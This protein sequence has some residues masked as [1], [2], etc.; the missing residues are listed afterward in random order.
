MEKMKK[1]MIG[2]EM[3]APVDQERERFKKL[4][5]KEGGAAA[6]AAE[7]PSEEE[8]E[9]FFAILRRIKVAVKYFDEKGRRGKEWREAVEQLDVTVD[10]GD[11]PAPDSEIAVLR[12]KDEKVI[13]NKA[14]DLN[15]VAPEAAQ[16]GGA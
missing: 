1:R 8:M 4:K 10:D 12:K 7:V 13:I 9:E 15:T 5:E 11:V 6:D 14:F 3:A 2:G 16:R